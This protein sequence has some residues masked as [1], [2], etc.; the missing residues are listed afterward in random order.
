[1]HDGTIKPG[2]KTL[3]INSYH[4]VFDGCYILGRT[5]RDVTGADLQAVFSGSALG[6]TTKRH[7]RS[8]LK[9]FYKYLESQ[10]ITKNIAN[11]IVLPEAEHRKSDQEI[12]TFTD[13][14]IRI[15]LDTTPPDHRLRLLVVL[16]IYTGARIGELCALTYSDIENGQITINKQLVEIDPIITERGKTKA[17]A[18]IAETKTK[19]SVRTLP[20]E[21]IDFIQKEIDHHRKWHRKEMRKNAYSTKYVFTTSSGELYFKSSLRTAFNRLCKKIGVAPKSIHV[22]RHTFGTKLAESGVPIQ[23]VSKMMGHDS[24]TVT[25]KYYVITG[26]EQKRAALKKLSFD[27]I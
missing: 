5:I 12:E 14:E 27:E 1:M 21:P 3:H 4:N 10:N 24:V 25:A 13:E 22:F 9:R 8:F 6:A 7:A 26:E 20:L 19:S 23:D 15:F 17:R 2:T 16:A 18:E 11:C